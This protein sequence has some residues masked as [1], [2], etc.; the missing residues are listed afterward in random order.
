[1]QNKER[2]SKMLLCL[3]MALIF[4]STFYLLLNY[5][6]GNMSSDYASHIRHALRG[7]GY[8]LVRWI[9][10]ASYS[11]FNSS[12]PFVFVM[13]LLTIGT[14]YSCFYYVK[15]I[16]NLLEIKT[17]T[18]RLLAISLSS[19]FIC[20]ICIP[21]WSNLYYKDSI[22]TQP[23]HN[24]TYTAMR[25][26]SLIAISIYFDIQSNYLKKFD[27]AKGALFSLFLFLT[28]FSKPSF[29]IAF[30]PVMLLVLIKD[31]VKTKTKSFKNAFVFGV[32]VLFACTILI[33]QTTMLFPAEGDSNSSIIFSV[34]N[35]IDYFSGDLKFPL[36]LILNFAFPMY[37]IFLEIKN[38]NKLDSAEKGI[39]K[40]T[41]L[42]FGISFLE[43]LFITETG[44]RA[45]DGNL[46]WGSIFFA[47]LIFIT[48]VPLL[49]K[50]RIKGC[51]GDREYSLAYYTYALHILFGVCYYALLLMGYYYYF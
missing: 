4:L 3:I 13:S 35:A 1:M 16:C 24:P 36:Y 34:G 44:P 14:A 15:H 18:L 41:L 31:F 45:N 5:S 17:N 48:C 51:I 50:M 39:L 42:M 22:S 21:D 37:V 7:Q 38:R 28:N 40:Q 47:Y 9:I 32:C 46:S 43:M 20:K 26:F 33:F 6:N 2:R 11:L 29:V 49:E 23:W 8:S 10:T 27:F 12:V 30:A 25:F 19:L